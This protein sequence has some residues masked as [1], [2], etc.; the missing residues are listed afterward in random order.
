M[1][2]FPVVTWAFPVRSGNAHVTPGNETGN[3]Y[4]LYC[5]V[6]IPVATGNAHITHVPTGNAHVTTG[7]RLGMP[8]HT[9]YGRH[10]SVVGHSH[11]QLGMTTTSIYGNAMVVP[12]WGWERPQLP[13]ML[14]MGTTI[15]SIY[16]KA[17]L[18]PVGDGNDHPYYVW[19]GNDHSY[20]VW[21][22][23]SFPFLQLGMTILAIYGSGVVLP[24]PSVGNGH[25]CHI[26]KLSSKN[27]HP[28]HVNTQ[29]EPW[30]ARSFLPLTTFI[31]YPFVSPVT[32][33]AV[34]C[35][36][37][38]QPS[39]FIVQVTVTRGSQ[40]AH[41]WVTQDVKNQFFLFLP[42][43]CARQGTVF[44][45]LAE[46]LLFT[47]QQMKY[48]SI[49]ESSQSPP[50]HPHYS[51]ARKVGIS[52]RCKSI[53]PRLLPIMG[54]PVNDFGRRQV[55]MVYTQDHG[56]IRGVGSIFAEATQSLLLK[57]AMAKWTERTKD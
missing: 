13:F 18:F 30:I 51:L 36:L 20:H 31:L 45:S 8:T 9:I 21:K 57:Q 37:H 40:L 15:T 44:H 52:D 53:H 26:W 49:N 34:P 11:K 41:I 48:N 19:K 47:T 38:R 1:W 10:A 33:L 2:A 3:A 39:G 54:E 25:Y 7:M 42:R 29:E 17:M 24:I 32:L 16:G 27:G 22:V 5:D 50:K 6:G 55:E 35:Q 14:G 46:S 56:R 23:W 4:V 12:S 28:L 43:V